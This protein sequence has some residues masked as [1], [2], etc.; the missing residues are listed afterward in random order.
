MDLPSHEIEAFLRRHIAGQLGVYEREIDV[1]T[2]FAVLG[3]DSVAALEVI[4]VLEDRIGA[5]VPPQ[6]ISRHRTIRALAA[7][8]GR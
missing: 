2:P 5:E 6:T 8:L 1:D 4:G 7:H 3:L